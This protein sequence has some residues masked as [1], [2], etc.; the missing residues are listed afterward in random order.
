MLHIQI[1]VILSIYTICLKRKRETKLFYVI[2]IL[3]TKKKKIA[4]AK[5]IKWISS[6]LNW[7]KRTCITIIVISGVNNDD[8]NY[9]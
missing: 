2:K 8:V 6:T 7:K 4:T 5:M 3:F 9:Y 1:Y